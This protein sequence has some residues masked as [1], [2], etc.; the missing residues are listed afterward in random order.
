MFYVNDESFLDQAC[1][2]KMNGYWHCSSLVSRLNA[3]SRR[4]DLRHEN[5]QMSSNLDLVLVPCI[6]LVLEHFNHVITLIVLLPCS[7]SL[8]FFSLVISWVKSGKTSKFYNYH[9]NVIFLA[10][11]KKSSELSHTMYMTNL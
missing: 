10:C 8:L 1:L 11:Y 5:K 3:R 7:F 2:A 6:I 4:L 9:D